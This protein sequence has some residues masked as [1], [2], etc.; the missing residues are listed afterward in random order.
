M[1]RSIVCF[2]KDYSS[3]GSCDSLT[4]KDERGDATKS[5]SDRL[6]VAGYT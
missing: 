4:A 1:R 3:T 5:D 2:L 6:R